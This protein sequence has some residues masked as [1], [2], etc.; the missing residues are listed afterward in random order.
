MENLSSSL[1]SRQS[2]ASLLGL[3][4]TH[5]LLWQASVVATWQDFSS[6]GHPDDF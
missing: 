4:I 1:V 6:A 3:L 5:R 2:E